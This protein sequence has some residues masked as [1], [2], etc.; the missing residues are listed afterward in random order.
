MILLSFSNINA[1]LEVFERPC[2]AFCFFRKGAHSVHGVRVL[3]HEPEQQQLEGRSPQ[4]VNIVSIAAHGLCAGY[5]KKL[6]HRPFAYALHGAARAEYDIGVFAF[7]L[8]QFRHLFKRINIVA[9]AQCILDAM[10]GKI[11][12]AVIFIRRS[13]PLFQIKLEFFNRGAGGVH[14]VDLFIHLAEQLHNR[15]NGL[16]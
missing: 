7:A 9:D 6:F 10:E 5:G 8:K 16:F 2:Q 3:L 4:P 11:E 15:G 1:G 12:N 14:M 13:G